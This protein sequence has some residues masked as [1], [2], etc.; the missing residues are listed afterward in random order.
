MHHGE[1]TLNDGHAIDDEVT[2]AIAGDEDAF[3]TLYARHATTTWRLAYALTGTR[4]DAV[5][6]T[7]ESFART[8]TTLQAS[9]APRTDFATLLLR[10][11][12]DAAIDARNAHGDA[13]PPFEAT[14]QTLDVATAF[15]SLPE[16]WRS[17]LWLGVVERETQAR[18]AA[19]IGVD[20]ADAAAIVSRA[21]RGLRH[22]YLR[23]DAGRGEAR[24]CDRA[25]A[26]LGAYVA[27]SL[28]SADIDKLERHLRLCPTCDG[29]Y[30]RLASLLDRLPH[31][32]PALPSMLEDDAR[33]AWTGAV[34]TASDGLGISQFGEKVLAGVAAFAAGVGVLGA[35]LV[36]V[37]GSGADDLAV[38]PIAPL[39]AELA[40]PRPQ[41][42][43]LTIDLDPSGF[44][45]DTGS[46]T[47]NSFTNDRDDVDSIRPVSAR[48]GDGPIVTD[49][50]D[51]S[52]DSDDASGGDT[53][54]NGNGPGGG[55]PGNGGSDSGD[56]PATPPTTDGPAGGAPVV[57]VGAD[58]GDVPVAVELGDD[59]GLTVGPIS[60]GSGPAPGGDTISVD[61]PLEALDPVVEPVNDV[62][63][64]LLG[65]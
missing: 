35:A 60:V 47:G 30:G 59:P 20:T 9:P 56:D 1:A 57:S 27:G 26:R 8:F 24:N 6:V 50:D 33:V 23:I 7:S 2:R 53:S 5:T 22:Q 65:G 37:S 64:G 36:S 25:V 13:A 44:G 52:G 32:V 62:L 12:R 63:N 61:G 18:V 38:S 16:R 28:P 29:R 39:V 51:G 3:R 17:A 19:V 49:L 54:P 40:T 11:T 15:A 46:S 45:S 21:R 48:T 58:L 4:T 42:L 34:T 55:G 14:E 10:T 31:L 43:D 41:G